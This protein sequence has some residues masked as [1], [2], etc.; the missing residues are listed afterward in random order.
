[1]RSPLDVSGRL[2]ARV[3]TLALA[4]LALSS[5]AEARAQAA[6]ATDAAI[7]L[8]SAFVADLDSIQA[9]YVALAEA[10]PAEKYSWRPAPGVRSIG[11]VFMHVASE[12]YVYT[13]MSHGATPSPVVGRG[14]EAFAT[15]ES[16]ATKENVL[17][18]LKEGFA[19]ARQAV[20]GVEPAN[21]VG[22]RKIYGR[23]FTIAQT[24]MMMSGDLHEHLGQLIAYARSNDVKPPWTR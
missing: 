10:I 11:E 16:A 9:K 2:T 17:K 8:R 21:L 19:Y 22:V 4:L 24:S 5:A 23:D 13:P 12:Y 6:G 14:R 20:N 15:F 18:H 7:A 1:M 3:A